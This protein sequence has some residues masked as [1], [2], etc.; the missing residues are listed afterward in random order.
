MEL[1][2]IEK[3]LL[4]HFFHQTTK[5]L[6]KAVFILFPATFILIFEKVNGI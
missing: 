2:D 6:A 4:A 5:F 1:W 3:Y